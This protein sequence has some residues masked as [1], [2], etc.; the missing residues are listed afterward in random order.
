ME[1]SGFRAFSNLW[2]I[3]P[4]IPSSPAAFLSD[5][6]CNGGDG[7]LGEHCEK[8]FA[9]LGTTVRSFKGAA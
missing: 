7:S 4:L 8:C 9:V 5:I 6:L 1:N 3:N 2:N